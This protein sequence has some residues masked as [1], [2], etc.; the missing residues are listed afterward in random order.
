MKGET[1]RRCVVIFISAFV[2]NFLWEHA[3]SVLYVSYQGGAITNILLLRAAL[4]DATVIALVSFP[5]FRFEP[6]QRQRWL[7]YALFVVFAIALEEWALVTGRWVYADAMPIIPI[8][9]VGLTPTIQLG[10]LGY[11]AVEIANHFH[12]KKDG[13]SRVRLS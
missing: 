13:L 12:T 2:L 1:A 8:L 9:H 7:L 4:F 5:F 11:A 10:L 3:H 6:L